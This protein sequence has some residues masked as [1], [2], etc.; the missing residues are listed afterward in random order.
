MYICTKSTSMNSTDHSS[1]I[2]FDEFSRLREISDFY[3]HYEDSYI[4][5][6]LR[7][8]ESNIFST[9]EQIIKVDGMALA[10]TLK[11]H[12]H[13]QVNTHDVE[14]RPG[15]LLIVSP[16]TSI[17]SAMSDT[18]EET[19]AYI[20]FFDKKFLQNVNI[21]LTSISLPITYTSPQSIIYLDSDEIDVLR[22]YCELLHLNTRN[23]ENPQLGRNI[24]TSLIAAMFYQVVMYYYRRIGAETS[25]D[26]KPLTRRHDYVRDFIKLVNINYMRERSV[27]YYASKLFISSK[28]LSLLVKEATGRSAAAWIDEFVIMEA[29]N[30]LRFSGKNIQQVAYALNFSTQSSFGKYFKHLTGMSPTEYQK[31]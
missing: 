16:N 26:E 13:L 8:S 24:A 22:R 6:R 10:L 18:R 28:Y 7:S 9:D 11:G 25:G 27:A 21:N 1:S 20:L 12:A 17:V 19:E 23:V 3:S 2:H 15:S 30:M 31:S 4:C 14:V 5:A 29:K